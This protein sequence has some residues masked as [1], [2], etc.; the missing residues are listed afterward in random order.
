MVVL[1]L[2][3]VAVGAC[4]SPVV[5]QSET[6]DPHLGPEE[7]VER[8]LYDLNGALQDPNITQTDVREQWALQLA[9]YF[10][11]NERL[12][13]R[14]EMNIMLHR[15]ARGLTQLEDDQ[16]LTVAIVYTDITLQEMTDDRATVQIVEGWLRLMQ[17]RVAENGR[18]MVE[19]DQGR[20][21]SEIIGYGSDALPLLQVG[22]Y[23]FITEW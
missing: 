8:F 14:A 6:I 16:Y 22:G 1:A 18:Q 4:S 23:W 7:V 2:V 9:N 19:K 5:P 21:L 12:D 15:F 20:P 3:L 11:P 10:V 13:Q 17:V